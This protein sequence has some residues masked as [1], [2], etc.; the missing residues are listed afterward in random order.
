MTFKKS[1]LIVFLALLLV[2]TMSCLPKTMEQETQ[3]ITQQQNELP[4]HSQSQST[5]SL[6]VDPPLAGDLETPIA[7]NTIQTTQKAEPPTPLPSYSFAELEQSTLEASHIATSTRV[8]EE[9]M[10]I[11]KVTDKCASND[12]INPADFEFNP[13]TRLVIKPVSDETQSLWL[14]SPHETTFESIPKPSS[15]EGSGD[16]QSISPNG[17]WIMFTQK[18]VQAGTKVL[19]LS[20]ING[21]RVREVGTIEYNI[22]PAW[23]SSSQK[24]WLLSRIDNRDSPI[25]VGMIDIFSNSTSSLN[26]IS[27][28]ATL[29]NLYFLQVLFYDEHWYIY[30]YTQDT[31]W[32]V[33]KWLEQERFLYQDK[34]AFFFNLGIRG[35]PGG[36]LFDIVV[37][38]PSSVDFALNIESSVKTDNYFDV[39]RSLELPNADL[40]TELLF[41]LPNR[42]AIAVKR[43][44]SFGSDEQN[45]IYVLDFS[46]AVLYAYC[47]NQEAVMDR[48]QVSLDGR[49]IAWT[50]YNAS[51][52]IMILDVITGQRGRINQAELIG[53]VELD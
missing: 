17:K 16:F 29:S 51:K 6:A 44:Q 14:W 27:S 12:E 45:Q 25:P 39:M 31:Q 43:F 47:H 50:T 20:P 5:K 34:Y 1:P 28:L 42:N 9:A 2:G 3:E 21:D 38:K 4:N 40:V 23:D 53:W 37:I 15:G 32:Q 26:Q 49:F 18:D 11:V 46:D 48:L 7:E 22:L 24:I 10:P 52:D 33:W 8:S 13:M 41:W 36:E 30:D 19:W 35:K